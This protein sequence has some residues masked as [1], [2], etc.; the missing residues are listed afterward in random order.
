MNNVTI[1][2]SCNGEYADRFLKSYVASSLHC[3]IKNNFLIDIVNP[4]NQTND[5]I[6]EISKN[7]KNFSFNVTSDFIIPL[8]W[9]NEKTYYACRRYLLLP[10]ILIKTKNVWVTDIDIIFIKT[11]PLISKNFAFSKSLLISDTSTPYDVI[12]KGIKGDFIYFD[13]N[14]LEYA[15]KIKSFIVNSDEKNWF[16]DQIA[17]YN[18]IN[19]MKD[20]ELIT[21]SITKR[22]D[23]IKYPDAFAISPGGNHKFKKSYRNEQNFYNNLYYNIEGLQ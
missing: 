1:F 15:N 6:V 22:S 10:D 20:Y 8:G 12:T 19:D 21:S 18:I 2:S 7:F 17:L 3:N 11:M 13:I 23:L 9:S 14:F 16:L 5:L 4:T